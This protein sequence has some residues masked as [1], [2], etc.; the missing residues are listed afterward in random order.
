MKDATLEALLLG[1]RPRRQAE[2][3]Q[4]TLQIMSHIKQQTVLG[5]HIHAAPMPQTKNIFMRLRALHGAGLVL[6]VIVVLVLLSGVTYAT[7]RFV[8]DLIKL[9]D[10]KQNSIGRT[11]YSVPTFKDCYVQGDITLDKFEVPLTVH[12]SDEDVEKTLRAKCE[13]LGISKFANDTWPTYGEHAQ[14][15]DGD[16]IYY[17]R[18]D[19]IGTIEKINKSSVTLRE[20]SGNVKTYSL[21]D[22]HAP[23]VY[24]RGERISGDA[25]NRG[26]YVYALVR[27]S[28]VYHTNPLAHQGQSQPTERGL[29]AVVKLSQPARYYNAMQQYV[30][31]VIPC[32]GNPDE[33]CSN[34]PKGFG[35]EVFPRLGEGGRPLD[36]FAKRS[37]TVQRII[38]GTITAI[39]DNA[40]TI[41]AGSGASYSVGIGKAE[42]ADY[43]NTVPAEY[44]QYVEDSSA[45]HVQMGSWLEVFYMQT[46]QG[47]RQQISNQDIVSVTLLT[48][49]P[50]EKR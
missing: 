15:Q 9:F 31:E 26:D 11:E 23:E 19:L 37:A 7:V 21:F 6:A 17:T 42:I 5:K 25:V 16:T 35:I 39:S 47:D 49:R 1:A 13:M 30:T 10:K 45:L 28:E 8:P 14:W 46:T 12:L 44:A 24:S 41:K 32:E 29:V 36:T 20:N 3:S 34:A 4:M 27:A 18:P 48:N 40:V 43:N 33:R 22:G 50:I 38:N 2:Y